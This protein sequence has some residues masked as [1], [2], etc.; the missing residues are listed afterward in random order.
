MQ[1]NLD[2][3]LVHEHSSPSEVLETDVSLVPTYALVLS[4]TKIT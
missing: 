2:I 4:Y 3:G 1:D